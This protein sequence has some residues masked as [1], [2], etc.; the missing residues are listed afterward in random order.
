MANVLFISEQYLKD[1]SVINTNVE[2]KQLRESIMTAQD[3]QIQQAIGS[4]MFE[5]LKT[6]VIANTV[7][8][9]N[10]ILI[11]DY[12]QRAIMYWVLADSPLLLSYK[13]TN[14]GIISH[15]SD[16][17]VNASQNEINFL[18]QNYKKK[19][20]WYTERVTAFLCA[21]S[22]LYPTY[23]GAIPEGGISPNQN[24]YT[25]GIFVG[26][27]PQQQRLSGGYGIDVFKE[28]FG[29]DC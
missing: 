20:E 18:A 10:L 27:R 1:N 9:A 12:L 6:Q 3:M 26:A 24:E 4:P 29:C 22:T 8:A 17:A 7:T 15:N 14:K 23:A 25:S 28:P 11:E 2:F 5:E 19:A 16:N 21:N 13:F